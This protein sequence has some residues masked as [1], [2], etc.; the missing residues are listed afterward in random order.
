MLPQTFIDRYRTP[1]REWRRRRIRTY[2]R[3]AGILGLNVAKTADYYSTLPVLERL[4]RNQERWN[5]PSAMVGVAFDMPEMK[6]LLDDLLR[7][8]AQPMLE[9]AVFSDLA[10][11]GFGPGYPRD[12]SIITYSLIRK[13]K[14]AR[15]IEVGSGLST[16]IARAAGSANAAEGRPMEIT[17]IEPFPSEPLRRLEGV[18]LIVSEVQDVPPEAFAVLEAGDILFI[19]STHVVA[20]DS[21]VSYLF[22]EIVPRV[23]PGVWTHIHDMPFPFNTPFPADMWVLGDRWPVFWQEAMLVQSFLAFNSAFKMRLSLPLIRH[24]DEPFIAQRIPGYATLS[25]DE[26]PSSSL[27]LERV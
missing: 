5:K 6:S 11:Q 2:Q 1:W 16:A 7:G 13:L 21:D 9:P 24:H 27:W 19:D 26:N 4:Y 17:C 18:R 14:P 8:F 15:Y 23:K 10:R 25:V 12:D 3:I 20:I 22:M